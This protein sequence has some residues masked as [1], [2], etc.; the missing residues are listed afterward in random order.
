MSE[1]SDK[2]L[3]FS[4]EVE[5]K[6]EYA[7]YFVYPDGRP[8]KDESMSRIAREFAEYFEVERYITRSGP[9]VQD[10]QTLFKELNTIGLS[11]TQI[12]VISESTQM[13]IMLSGNGKEKFHEA[14]Q[15]S[16]VNSGLVAMKFIND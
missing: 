8:L 12:I 13:K 7:Y 6:F 11:R 4:F 16:E 14:L 3:K 2:K 10:P 1:T 15:F 9:S 5:F